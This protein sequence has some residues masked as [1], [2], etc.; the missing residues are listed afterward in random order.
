MKNISHVHVTIKVVRLYDCVFNVHRVNVDI[1]EHIL[2]FVLKLTCSVGHMIV[3][4]VC[5]QRP[6]IVPSAFLQ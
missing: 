6:L 3:A 5:L 1:Q 2:M 4:V